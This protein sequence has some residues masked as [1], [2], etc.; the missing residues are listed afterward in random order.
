MLRPRLIRPHQVVALFGTS[1]F[2]GRLNTGWPGRYYDQACAL[3]SCLGPFDYFNQGKGSQNSDWGLANIGLI[4]NSRPTHV[5]LETF[6]INDSALIGG[7]PEVSRANHTTNVTAMVAAIRAA[8]ADVVIALLTMN[9]VSAGGA[10]LRPH[11]ADQYYADDVGLAGTLG[12]DLIDNYNGTVTV[13]GG[14]PKPLDAAVTNGATPFIIAPTAGYVG[15]AEL[16][17]WNPADKS[18][19]ITLDAT[20]LIATATGG[21]MVRDNTAVAAKVHFETTAGAAGAYNI[22]L[23]NAGAALAGYPGIDADSIGLNPNG[24]V[25]NNGVIGGAGI[26]VVN[27]GDV[28]GYEVDTVAKLIYFMKGATRSAGFDYSGL[29]GGAIYP[30]FGAVGAGQAATLKP[31]V[32]GDGL[33]PLQAPVDTYLMPNLIAWTAAKQ[34][35]FWPA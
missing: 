26:G 30:A 13:P 28:I 31:N 14:W 11:L 9:G 27:P 25:Y 4:A 16:A 21:G 19:N 2:E 18:A 20:G 10:A 24:S 12:C 22:G 6:S 3:P 15:Q 35:A 33:H 7:V 23:A 17:T 5:L 29:G 32:L 8:R 1:L 34:A